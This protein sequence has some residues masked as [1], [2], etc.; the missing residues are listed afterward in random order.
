MND[1]SWVIIDTETSGLMPPICAVEIAGQRMKGWEP[2]GEPFRVL[3][4]HDVPI[5][6][7]AESVHGYSRE[8]LRQHGEDPNKAHKAFHDYA[9]DL[10]IVAY[11][12]SFDWNRVLEPEY[13][14]LNVPQTGKR[15]FCALTLA[16]RVINET[17]NYKLETIKD[18][19]KLSNAQSHRGINDVNVVV[20][21]FSRIFRDRLI[22]AGIVGFN[23]VAAFSKKVPVAKC[24]EELKCAI[25]K[26]V[27]PRKKKSDGSAY[28]AELRGFC[29]GIMADGVLQDREIYDLQRMMASCPVEKTPEMDEV[30]NLLE[31]IYEDG[32]VTPDEHNELMDTLKKKFQL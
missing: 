1:E 5:D 20:S 12:I 4:N 21:L 26:Q 29:K 24:L 13:K 25:P 2:E 22:A 32:I 31:R 8:Y 3:L 30:L 16:R 18:H 19:F 10:P 9:E 7:M 23:N 28:Y 15:G 11:N 27:A 6:P 14:R 17:E